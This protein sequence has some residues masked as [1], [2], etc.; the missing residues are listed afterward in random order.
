MVVRRLRADSYKGAMPAA[1]M[2]TRKCIFFTTCAP[3]P[4]PRI[5]ISS[6]VEKSFLHYVFPTY[7]SCD[8]LPAIEIPRLRSG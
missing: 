8:S 2:Q 7:A 4:S 5:V 3:E 1:V 6:E